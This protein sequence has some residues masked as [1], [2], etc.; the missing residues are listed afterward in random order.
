VNDRTAV[1]LFNL[2]GPDSLKSVRPF[3]FNLFSDPDI[4]QFPFAFITQR[5][6]AWIVARRRTAE[7]SKGYAAIGGKSPLFENTQEQAIALQLALNEHTKL[8]THRAPGSRVLSNFSG[9]DVYVCMRYW[10]PLTD[11]VVAELKR[12][13]Y[14]KLVLLPLYPHFS[15]T[16]TGS[17]LNAFL[18][19]CKRQRYR[20]ELHVVEHW[21]LQPDYLRAVVEG[22]LAEAAKL[23]DPDPEHIELVFSAHGLPQKIVDDGDPYEAHIRATY[24]AVRERLAWPH[25]TLCFQSRVGPLTWLRPYTEDVIREKGRAGAKQILVYPIAFVSDHIETLYELGIQYAEL[26]KSLGVLHYRVVPALNSNPLLIDALRKLVIDALS[27][28]PVTMSQWPN[29][30]SPPVSRKS[31]HAS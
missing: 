14:G 8:D 3:L 6:F 31:S 20:P 27:D 17:S 16:T 26:A 10:H 5:F 25:S 30:A 28:E 4:F 24:T 21:H 2:G 13:N 18:R 15:R 23:P 9:A 11:A 7:A 19:E 29:S 12:K 22:V 1:V